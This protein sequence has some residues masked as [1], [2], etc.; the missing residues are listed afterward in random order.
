VGFQNSATS[1]DL[2]FYAARSY[3]L[4]RPPRTGQ[5]LIRSWERSATGVVGPGRAKLAAAMR[6][7]SV[8]M[9]LIPGQDGPQV[10]RAE[11]EHRVGDLCPGGEHEPF[12]VSVR[13]RAA[14][15]D[16]RQWIPDRE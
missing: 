15:R 11:D 6:P 9:G 8:V 4:M 13:T 1:P 12:R 10:P 7:P 2:R 5:R 14:G 3:S 16:K